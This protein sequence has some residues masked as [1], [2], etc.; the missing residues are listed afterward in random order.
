MYS[1]IIY[2]C[3]CIIFSPL[4]RSTVGCRIAMAFKFS[5]NPVTRGLVKTQMAG[6]I[7]PPRI[8]DSVDLKKCPI[9]CIS[10]KF[11]GDDV[12]TTGLET[13]LREPVL[14]VIFLLH[15]STWGY[16][17]E[18]TPEIW[19]DFLFLFVAARCFTVRRYHASSIMCTFELFPIF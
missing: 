19:R 11:P 17:L 7:S 15:F 9:I 4:L 5:C 8:S 16:I 13:T 10:N 14:Y 12:D 1:I 6:S 2:A 18:I 3:V